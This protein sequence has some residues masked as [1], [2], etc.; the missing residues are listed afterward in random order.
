M[1]ALG[2]SR[3]LTSLLFGVSALDPATYAAVT[4]V[5]GIVALGACL[6]PA[7]RAARV[8]PMATLRA[9]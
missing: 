3:L 1:A 4:A 5:L 7:F 9:E 6:V 8:D 2:L